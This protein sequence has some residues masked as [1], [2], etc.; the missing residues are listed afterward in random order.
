MVWILLILFGVSCF[1][2]GCEYTKK[3]RLV[4]ILAVIVCLIALHGLLS[5]HGIDFVQATW[6]G[7]VTLMSRLGGQ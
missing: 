3:E 6:N 1:E 2:L 7:G 4:A 5:S